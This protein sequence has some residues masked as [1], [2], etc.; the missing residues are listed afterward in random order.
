MSGYANKTIDIGPHIL[1]CMN[2]YLASYAVTAVQVG[3]HGGG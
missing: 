1:A 2:N 3:V